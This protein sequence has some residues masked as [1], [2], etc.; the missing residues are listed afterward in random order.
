M[1]QALWV[2]AVG[3]AIAG[4]FFQSQGAYAA[5]T[6]GTS[7]ATVC[8]YHALKSPA[9]A[10]LGR[11]NEQPI[12]LGRFDGGKMPAVQLDPGD[13]VTVRVCDYNPVL[14]VYTIDEQKEDVPDLAAATALATA[15]QTVTASLAGKSGLE[16]LQVNDLSINELRAAVDDLNGRV[17]QIPD[18]AEDTT[19]LGPEALK[20]KQRTVAAWSAVIKRL[21]PLLAKV[22]AIDAASANAGA[23]TV[24]NP[25]NS[26]PFPSVTQ[27]D[28]AK[29][30]LRVTF[31]KAADADRLLGLLSQVS[32]LQYV[33]RRVS[34]IKA[35]AAT[36]S[37]FIDTYA[38]V[39]SVEQSP[40][41]TVSHSTTSIVKVNVTVAANPAFTALLNDNTK[42]FQQEKSTSGG[43]LIVKVEPDE[44]VHLSIAPGVIYSF[45]KETKYTAKAD[46][47]GAFS[48][49]GDD[50]EY[51]AVSGAVVLNITPTKYVGRGKQFF[52]QVGIAPESGKIAF[53]LGAGM[54]LYDRAVVSAGV[55]YQERDVLAPGLSVGAPLASQDDLKI[56]QKFK[57]GA[58]IGLSFNLGSSSGD[59]E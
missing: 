23:L 40:K 18:L 6:P 13:A 59:K 36:L 29:D 55:I 41:V 44:A 34:D 39:Y 33:T 3:T 1:K 27:L 50:S 53:L 52:G 42:K 35:S 43:P 58:Y 37:Q 12:P 8:V 30:R 16:D 48:V 24:I 26:K 51:A 21:Q 17:K 10:E 38:K 9:A 22:E 57:F 54:S 19:K 46:D 7:E 47:A 5:V 15:I 14:F 20:E 45:V 11:A 4:L 28:D 32:Y 31:A 2:R 49:A 25:A 56:D